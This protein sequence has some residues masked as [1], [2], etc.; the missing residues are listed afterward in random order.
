M[1]AS[2]RLFFRNLN[3]Y[4]PSLKSQNCPQETQPGCVQNRGAPAIPLLNHHVHFPH[5]I[6]RNW[7]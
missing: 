5:W 1:L 6:A 7:D 3:L 4:G 2:E